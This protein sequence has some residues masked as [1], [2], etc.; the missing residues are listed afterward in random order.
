MIKDLRKQR[1]SVLVVILLVIVVLV[2]VGFITLQP[3]GL[4]S[5]ALIQNLPTKD[6]SAPISQWVAYESTD[7]KFTL[8]YPPDFTYK[9]MQGENNVFAL[10]F[11]PSEGG[12]AKVNSIVLRV[13]NRNNAPSLQDWANKYVI[14]YESDDERVQDKGYVL[15][16]V[17]DMNNA[18]V[19]GKK[20]ITYT[21]DNPYIGGKSE[22]TMLM[23][24]QYVFVFLH[25]QGKADSTYKQMVE[26]LAY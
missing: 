4:L 14:S 11:Q 22:G 13:L 20:A 3:G 23:S 9:K 18:T 17:K 12:L 2:V 6:T 16:G 24:N 7:P 5:K 25:P 1:G 19:G 10:A 15:F 8:K 26:S 21:L